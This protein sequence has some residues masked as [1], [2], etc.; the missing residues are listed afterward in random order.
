MEAKQLLHSSDFFVSSHQIAMLYWHS[1][2]VYKIPKDV[3]TW[4][5]QFNERREVLKEI[6]LND[7]GHP[8]GM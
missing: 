3:F 7:G 1:F 8:T 4:R 6:C 2:P 5:V